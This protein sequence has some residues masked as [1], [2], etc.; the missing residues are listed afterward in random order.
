[1][2]GRN[3]RRLE[4]QCAA[5]ET[6]L[7]LSQEVQAAYADG[8]NRAVAR[9]EKAESSLRTCVT[10]AAQILGTDAEHTED[11]LNPGVVLAAFDWLLSRVAA[12]EE[13][14]P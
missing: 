13:E 1:M 3:E 11:G 14:I 9:A 10:R 4:A 6:A 5:M 7:R 12:V 8:E 2:S